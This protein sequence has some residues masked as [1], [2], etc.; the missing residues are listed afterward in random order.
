MRIFLEL[1]MKWNRRVHRGV[2]LDGIYKAYIY[3]TYDDSPIY[4]V[5]MA[6]GHYVRGNSILYTTKE[7]CHAMAK[8]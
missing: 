3:R 1:K 6:I 4:D 5:C 8:Y 7:I 2:T